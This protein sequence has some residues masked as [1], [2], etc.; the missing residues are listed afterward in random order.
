MY[1]RSRRPLFRR[2]SQSSI[3]RIFFLAIMALWGIWLIR[4]VEVGA[5]EQVGQPTPTATRAAVSLTEE[6]DVY[7]ALG[8]LDASIETYR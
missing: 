7:F 2:Q 3:Y 6:G 4:G 1:M 5:I 8:K